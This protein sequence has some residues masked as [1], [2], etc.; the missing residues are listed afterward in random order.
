MHEREIITLMR[1]G[2]GEDENPEADF[3]HWPV[4][5]SD[6]RLASSVDRAVHGD[7]PPGEPLDV[8]AYRGVNAA[9]SDLACAG[10]SLPA[11]QL[12]LQIPRS[13]DPTMVTAIAAGVRHAIR[14]NG[15]T[16]QNG[17]NTTFGPTA[18]TTSVRG[19]GR[20]SQLPPGRTGAAPGD[21][22]V[23][24]RRPG[25]FNAALGH[26]NHPAGDVRPEWLPSAL[27]GGLPELELGRLLVESESITAVIDANDCLLITL[28]DLARGSE[29]GIDL[30]GSAVERLGEGLPEAVSLE[31]LLGPPSGD[32]ALVMTLRPERFDD[33]R[34]AFARLGRRPW[35]LGRCTAARGQLTLDGRHSVAKAEVAQR[36]WSP[37][38]AFRY[39]LPGLPEVV[40]H[41]QQG[42]PC[43]RRHGE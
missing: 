18:L 17:C 22:V 36:R 5:G 29:V 40:V 24:S 11:V 10:V 2:L 20:R 4:P 35:H 26:L 13:A 34:A 30:D 37:S 16:L 14:I 19:V 31:C 9:L 32:L 33:V 43:V 25:R 8:W 39:P 15:A 23:V 42:E 7:C 6:V 3:D 41:G 27:L 1:G 38:T 28:D 12:D 21:L